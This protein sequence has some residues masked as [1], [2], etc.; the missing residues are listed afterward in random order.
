MKRIT[1]KRRHQLHDLEDTDTSTVWVEVNL[2][3]GKPIL[4]SSIYRQWSLPNT[5]NILNSKTTKAQIDRW[6]KILDKLL[7]ASKENEEII[8]LTDDNLDYYNAVFDNTYK[9][10]H[11]SRY[12]I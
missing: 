8:V 5:M 9:I 10:I 11:Y 2:N 7:L 12:V 3:K 4:V 1:H 6:A